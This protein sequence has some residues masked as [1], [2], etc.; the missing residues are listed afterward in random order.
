MQPALAFIDDFGFFSSTELHL[1]A[2]YMD[3]GNHYFQFGYE[4]RYSNVL[5]V[6]VTPRAQGWGY[7]IEFHFGG[8]RD[9]TGQGAQSDTLPPV[10]PLPVDPPESPPGDD[11]DDNDNSR[12]PDTGD[13]DSNGSN[14]SGN[15]STGDNTYP[16]DNNRN[17]NDNTTP[18]VSGDNL[19]NGSN[20]GKQ[21]ETGNEDITN[22]NGHEQPEYVKSVEIDYIPAD[23]KSSQTIIENTTNTMANQPSVQQITL[24]ADELDNLRTTQPI[25]MTFI[26]NNIKLVI[27]TYLLDGLELGEGEVF[28]V[29]L[30]MEG[31]TFSVRLFAGEREIRGFSGETFLVYILYDTEVPLSALYCEDEQ[32]NR[33]YMIGSGGDKVIFRL[34][35]TGKYTIHE[36]PET[37]TPL[38]I[39]GKEIPEAFSIL[40]RNEAESVNN[41]AMPWGMIGIIGGVV[42]VPT[43]TLGIRRAKLR[44]KHE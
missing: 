1:S 23:E 41:S 33:Y 3:P 28:A 20:E 4:G 16:Q 42:L 11:D 40:N 26:E 34:A 21:D 13:G 6:T 39:E 22:I 17:T 43:T 18:I 8:D 7:D 19:F 32:G 25:E 29:E 31:N 24:D 10:D 38:V 15:P 9:G 36:E 35:T 14:P 12:L 2:Y 30:E 44:K 5:Q 27:P 37:D